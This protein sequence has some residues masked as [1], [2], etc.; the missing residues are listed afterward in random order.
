MPSKRARTTTPVALVTGSGRGIGRA[1]SSVLG[2]EGHAVMVVDVDGPRVA[3][4]V[5]ELN[6]D[7]FRAA[8]ATGDVA[9]PDDAERREVS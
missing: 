2:R 6:A 1:I 3:T 7:G 8:G 9:N 5:S 4:A